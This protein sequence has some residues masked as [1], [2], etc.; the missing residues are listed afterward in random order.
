[1]FD[2]CSFFFFSNERSM[3]KE[4]EM[5]MYCSFFQQVDNLAWG[6]PLLVLLVEQDLPDPSLGLLQIRYLP[7]AFA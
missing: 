1:M 4:T 7:K 3:K 5:I 2:M 6:A